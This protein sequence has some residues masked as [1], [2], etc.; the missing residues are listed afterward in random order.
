MRLRGVFKLPQGPRNGRGNHRRYPDQAAEVAAE[1][2]VLLEETG[3]FDE[4]F[5][6]AVDRGIDVD[7]QSVTGA[8]ENF[9]TSMLMKFS[10]SRHARSKSSRV[11]F[12]GPR[13]GTEP[14]ARDA[15][16]DLATG[17]IPLRH[18]VEMLLERVFGADTVNNLRKLG[19]LDHIGDSLAVLSLVALRNAARSASEEDLRWGAQTARGLLDYAAALAELFDVTGGDHPDLRTRAVAGLG[20]SMRRLRVKSGMGAS[21]LA[22]ALL[23]FAA[24]ARTRNALNEVVQYINSELPAIRANAAAAK[25]APKKWRPYFGHNGLAA[26]ASLRPPE[27]EKVLS[28]TRSWLADHPEEAK[29]VSIQA[30]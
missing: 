2:R 6:L 10:G 22:P 8:Y 23:L 4:A 20:R 3:N 9:T 25:S 16:I 15:F 1:F 26:F 27:A 11:R 29:V 13:T 28:F 5:L 7:H 19:N 24:D 18:Q 14:E 12:S 30:A 21:L 17:A